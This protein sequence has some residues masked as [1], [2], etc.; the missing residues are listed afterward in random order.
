MNAF[1]HE[2][3][4]KEKPIPKLKKG[5]FQ[6]VRDRQYIAHLP[7]GSRLLPATA[8][9]LHPLSSSLERWET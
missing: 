7:G 9:A 8:A 3:K 1:E 5:Q 2:E 4:V 6:T